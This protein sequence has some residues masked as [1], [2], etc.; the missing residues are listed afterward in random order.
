MSAHDVVDSVMEPL[1][2]ILEKVDRD[3]E[4]LE[5]RLEEIW[6]LCEELE[7]LAYQP[8]NPD[9]K[10]PEP[11]AP[12]VLE[13]ADETLKLLTKLSRAVGSALRLIL[14]YMHP[15]TQVKVQPAPE[16]R[17]QAPIVIQ[18]APQPAGESLASQVRSF[19]TGPWE[20]LMLKRRLEYLERRERPTITQPVVH[21]D[22][23]DI[24]RQLIPVII[25]TKDFLA[26]CLMHHRAKR[27]VYFLIN[28]YETMRKRVSKIVTT[29]MAFLEATHQIDLRDLR[30]QEITQMGYL[31]RIAEAAAQAP[32][33]PARARPFY[34]GEIR[35][36]PYRQR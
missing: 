15:E 27:S 31:T 28:V 13:K 17:T 4:R 19:F 2:A 35:P 7:D 20:Y 26:N 12:P 23:L 14:R 33:P 29:A 18:T 22:P 5:K 9:L 25:E 6:G 34:E 16:R 36:P 11:K 10:K 32:A 1:R 8:Y 21:R 24:G 3:K 30:T